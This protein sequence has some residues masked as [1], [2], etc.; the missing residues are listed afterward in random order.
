MT[1]IAIQE[2]DESGNPVSLVAR[3][4]AKL[5]ALSEELG[6]EGIAADV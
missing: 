2:A 5:S 6:A 1:H 3:D 4:E